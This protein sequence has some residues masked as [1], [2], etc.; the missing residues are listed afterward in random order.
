MSRAHAAAHYQVSRSSAI[1]WS[2]RQA[3]T[4]SPAALPMGGK[5]PFTLTDQE[6]CIRS[7]M[8]EK[9]DLTGREPMSPA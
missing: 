4:G 3:K 7:R 6:A 5:E 9:P 2:K 8:E 1:R